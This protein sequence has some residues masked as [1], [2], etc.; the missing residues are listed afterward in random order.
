MDNRKNCG[1]KISENFCPNCGQK[2][3]KRINRKYVTDELQYS[4]FHM[5]GG[6]LYTAKSLLKNP[7]ATARDYIDGNRIKHYK[8][9]LMAFVLSGFS[10]FISYKIIGFNEVTEA[11]YK[12][13]NFYQQGTSEAMNFLSSYFSL[14]MLLLIPIFSLFSWL[15]F[16]NWGQ[17]YYED[18]IMNAF[19][20]SYYNLISFFLYPFFYLVK[21]KPDVFMILVVLTYPI[22]FILL[23]LFYKGFYREKSFA[24]IF[25]RMM[26]FCRNGRIYLSGNFIYNRNRNG[27]G[28][29]TGR[30]QINSTY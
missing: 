27:T 26:L 5:N 14:F 11:F 18:I 21:D 7:G 23:Y 6:F 24:E 3:Y 9:I 4:V 19:F 25:A 20:L 15:S 29:G 10:A 30:T 16:R 28:D 13:H 12:N 17:N 2:K 1:Q 22:I 8:P